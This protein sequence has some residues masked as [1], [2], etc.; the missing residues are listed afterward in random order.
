M[1][2]ELETKSQLEKN[3]KNQTRC[4]TLRNINIINTSH[5]EEEYE[6]EMTNSHICS[7]IVNIKKI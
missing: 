3:V 4:K 2:K 5:Q 7:E 1:H 6:K